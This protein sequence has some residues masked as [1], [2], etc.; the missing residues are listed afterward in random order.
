MNSKIILIIGA[1][2]SATYAIEYLA[3]QCEKENWKLIVA[4]ADLQTAKQKISGFKNCEAKQLDINNE[5]ERSALIQQAD[6]VISMMPPAFHSLVLNDCLKYRK[7][8]TNAS[9]VTSEMKLLNDEFKKK[10]DD[11]IV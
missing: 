11:S 3:A 5:S 10:Q 6:L 4:D 1:G 8:F 7:H 2:K 9:Y